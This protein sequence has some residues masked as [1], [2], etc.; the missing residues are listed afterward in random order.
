MTRVALWVAALLI[1]L[2]AIAAGLSVH[3]SR[4]LFDETLDHASLAR[5]IIAPADE[6]LTFARI[7][8]EDGG[9]RVLLV[10]AW[11]RGHVTGVDLTLRLR[12]PDAD[13]IRMY[14]SLG[15]AA[16][17]KAGQTDELVRVPA[18]M[19]EVPFDAHERNLGVGLN[20]DDHASEA[21]LDDP[22]FLF[23]KYAQPTPA[24]ADIARERARRLD[25]EAE[26]GIVLIDDLTSLD[27]PLP[28]IALVLAND[29]TDRWTLVRNYR[30]GAPIGTTGFADGKSGKGFAPIGPLLV[31]PR[32]PEVFY[33]RIELRLY[34]NGALRQRASA[35]LMRWDPHEILREIVL[36]A[37]HEYQ[38]G[39][40]SE[41][42]LPMM[43][44]P[45]R[46]IVFSGTPAGVIFR[47]LNVWNPWLY[48]EPGDEI[49]I[50]GDYLGMI[51][52]RITP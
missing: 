51:R 8:G 44:V 33:R 16:L 10:K 1:G 24:L 45:R 6:A 11:E 35:D 17:A 46:T 47:P 3:V 48:L 22:P 26:L 36:R 19:L 20:Y 31:V 40:R 2:V 21:G 7:R 18:S 15:H 13:P 23:P 28:R 9:L 32:Q 12:R 50:R 37:G 49:V 27:A 29:V 25:Y 42:L 39:G 34:L 5:V 52:N 38:Y 43:P 4:P 41:P 30:R 14:R